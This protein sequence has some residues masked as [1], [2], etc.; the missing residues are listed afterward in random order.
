MEVYKQTSTQECKKV[1]MQLHAYIQVCKH[2]KLRLC[3]YV[4]MQG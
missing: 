1:C 3:M 2:A 4:I